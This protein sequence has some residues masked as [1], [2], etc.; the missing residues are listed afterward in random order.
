MDNDNENKQNSSGEQQK[1]D[2]DVTENTYM[3]CGLSIGT[4]C[5]MLAGIFLFDN[6]GI[7]LS[8]GI[9]LGMAIGL[10]IK[11]KK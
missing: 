5:G 3:I 2:Y 10:C 8:L 7:G 4:A 9:G 1:S 6:A 11:K